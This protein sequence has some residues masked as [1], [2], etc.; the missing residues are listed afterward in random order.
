[1]TRAILE[2][3]P[4]AI[5]SIPPVQMGNSSRECTREMANYK[6]TILVS[7]GTAVLM[8]GMPAKVRK[9]FE[10]AF[11]QLETEGYQFLWKSKDGK[12]GEWSCER[13]VFQN[14]WLRQPGILGKNF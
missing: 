5:A 7:F 3:N 1:M 6:G 2:R 14:A 12:R 4:E 10:G 13:N 8:E 9:A 11:F